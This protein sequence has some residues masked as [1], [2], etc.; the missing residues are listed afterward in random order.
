MPT[1]VLLDEYNDVPTV[2]NPSSAVTISVAP[3]G[4]GRYLSIAGGTS[5]ITSG[6][7]FLQSTQVDL[8][9]TVCEYRTVGATAFD[10]TGTTQLVLTDLTNN[11]GSVVIR[12]ITNG[13]NSLYIINPGVL[14]TETIPLSS[15]SGT[16][17]IA[18]VTQLLLISNN[19]GTF[20]YTLGMLAADPHVLCLDGSRLDVY[21]PGFYRYYDNGAKDPALRLVANVEVRHTARGEDYAAALWVHTATSTSLFDFEEG[22][23]GEERIEHEVRDPLQSCKLTFVLERAYNTVGM[24]GEWPLPFAAVGGLMAGRVHAIAYLESLE[25]V[26]I[27]PI[28]LFCNG[29]TSH[30]LVCGSMDPH[31]VSFHGARVDIATSSSS[32]PALLLCEEEEGGGVQV[33]ATF[34][35]E[36]RLKRMW[37]QESTKGGEENETFGFWANWSADDGS[38][39]VSGSKLIGKA[40]IESGAEGVAEAWIGMLFVRVHR[41][42]RLGMYKKSMGRSP[43]RCPLSPKLMR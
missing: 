40:R 9:A 2:I 30:A 38:V 37:V 39:F 18:Q 21:A 22:M 6:P 5:Q 11:S 32:S 42:K 34:D 7:N 20:T 28:A 19:F 31:I 24:R 12:F 36:R 10:M 43:R 15:F 41:F 1:N 4:V 29:T 27:R 8:D 17:D 23:R 14:R 13:G 35:A 26:P 25:P 33:W 3:G 16:M